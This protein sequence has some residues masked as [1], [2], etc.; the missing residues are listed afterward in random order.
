MVWK[1]G[2]ERKKDSIKDVKQGGR[3]KEKKIKKKKD[4]ISISLFTV[5]GYMY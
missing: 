2:G 1:G 5:N 3:K 4:K